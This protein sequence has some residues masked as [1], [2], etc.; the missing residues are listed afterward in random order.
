MGGSQLC[1]NGRY[2]MSCSFTPGD[3]GLAA[4]SLAFPTKPPEEKHGSKAS[5]SKLGILGIIYIPSKNRNR[6]RI[7]L[8]CIV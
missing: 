4:A 3:P 8:C 1:P 2:P 7:V 5:G 6:Y